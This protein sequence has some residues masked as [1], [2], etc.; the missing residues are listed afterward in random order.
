MEEPKII[1]YGDLNVDYIGRMDR[2]PVPDEEMPIEDLTVHCGG[3][4]TNVAVGLKRLGHN[5]SFLGCIGSDPIG[6]QMLS[7]LQSDDIDLSQVIVRPNQMT[8]MVISIIDNQGERR[9]MTHY[10]A[11]KE[12]SKSDLADNLF[13]SVSILH[14]SSP[15]LHMVKPL[16]EQAKRKGLV[17]SF[18]PGSL[19]CRHGMAVLKPLLSLV[20]ILFLNRI[21]YQQLIDSQNKLNFTPFFKEGCKTV[22]YKKGKDGC[23]LQTHEG[24]KVESIG[25]NVTPLDTTGAGDAFAAGFLSGLIRGNSYEKCIKMANATGA[26]SVTAKGAK[27]AL[28][29]RD[30]LDRFIS[31]EES[32]STYEVKTK[33]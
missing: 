21:E 13:D 6:K 15:Q 14:M 9:L 32:C 28:P 12:I 11:N 2:L 26:L 18:D 16:L 5:V 25:Y 24:L 10:G 30:K 19:I 3:A 33:L 20:D 27:G 22:I 4:A 29:N 31:N 23:I 7:E 17:T 8:G 1:C